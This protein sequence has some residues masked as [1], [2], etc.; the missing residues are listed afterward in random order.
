MSYGYPSLRRSGWPLG[1][2]RAPIGYEHP[3]IVVFPEYTAGAWTRQEA[4][5][6]YRRGER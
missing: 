4:R 3:W 2:H 6:L 1:V 5:D